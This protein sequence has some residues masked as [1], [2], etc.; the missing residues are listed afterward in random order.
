MADLTL[1]FHLYFLPLNSPFPSQD[2]QWKQFRT[3]EI[4]SV[5]IAVLMI[6]DE[7]NISIFMNCVILRLYVAWYWGFHFLLYQRVELMPKPKRNFLFVCLIFFLLLCLLDCCGSD[8]VICGV[9]QNQA[10]CVWSLWA[11][12]AASSP[13]AGTGSQ[14][15]LFTILAYRLFVIMLRW[16]LQCGQYSFIVLIL[17]RHTLTN[18]IPELRW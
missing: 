9:H 3:Q 12:S 16:A 5:W 13:S 11:L 8:R 1:L 7:L 18:R 2:A 14:Q 17:Y 4:K 10:Y 15:V 6:S